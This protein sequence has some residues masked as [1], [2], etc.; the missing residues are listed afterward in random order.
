[1]R[2]YLEDLAKRGWDR[3]ALSRVK[4]GVLSAVI[5]A[6]ECDKRSGAV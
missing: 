5:D 2:D 3:D 6:T 1:M 4:S